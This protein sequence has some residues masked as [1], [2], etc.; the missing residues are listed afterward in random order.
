MTKCIYHLYLCD[1]KNFLQGK[2]SFKGIKEYFDAKIPLK[3]SSDDID[4]CYTLETIDSFTVLFKDAR[5]LEK[6]FNVRSKDH[7]AIV[8]SYYGHQDNLKFSD[9]K[10]HD[11]LYAEDKL[12]VDSFFDKEKSEKYCQYLIQCLSIFLSHHGDEILK[13]P[14]GYFISHSLSKE[15]SSKYVDVG[16][17]KN[18]QLNFFVNKYYQKRFNYR[19]MRILYLY[20]KSKDAFM[21]VKDD[22]VDVKKSSKYYLYVKNDYVKEDPNN[23]FH[24]KI[25]LFSSDLSSIDGYTVYFDTVYDVVKKF[26]PVES[27][28]M[29]CH[30]GVII[31]AATKS[32]LE[33]KQDRLPVF[34]PI[35]LRGDEK[36]FSQQVKNDDSKR[37]YN[38]WLV[39]QCLLCIEDERVKM[40]A[41]NHNVDLYV[42]P[43]SSY[44]LLHIKNEDQSYKNM[45]NVY[46]I[47]KKLVE[48][49]NKNY[50]RNRRIY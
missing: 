18:E 32:I 24:D 47:L 41:L 49:R 3:I 11:V 9:F 23:F 38:E 15:S 35:L 50:E 31:S 43:I 21:D 26:L 27:K 2:K 19:E 25:M 29:S 13:S 40:Y 48:R 42:A 1:D 36:F 7:R 45:R 14:V 12:F 10:K 4:A 34:H 8:L 22:V 30:E 46:F 5:D 16:K 33:K 28:F 20:L 17:I 37:E 6:K 39:N 44:E